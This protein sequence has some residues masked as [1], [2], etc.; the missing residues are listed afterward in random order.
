[1]EPILRPIVRHSLSFLFMLASTQ[2][3]PASACAILSKEGAAE[4]GR[5]FVEEFKTATLAL[6]QQADLVFTGRLQTL[7]FAPETVT[8]PDGQ[9]QLLQ[10]HEAVFERVDNIK[11]HYVPGQVLTF[12][13]NKNRVSIPLGCRLPFWLFPQENGAGELYLVYARDGKILR[14]NHILTDT[15][16]MDARAEEAYIRGLQE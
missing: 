3:V 9:Q 6:K 2:A 14:T 1:M 12:A 13:T 10:N 16:T 7:T 5:Q 4:Q 11:G 15:Q 8:L